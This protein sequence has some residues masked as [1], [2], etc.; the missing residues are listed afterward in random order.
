MR[1]NDEDEESEA[2]TDSDGNSDGHR[3]RKPGV[4]PEGVV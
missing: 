3:R 2:A 1:G 4:D